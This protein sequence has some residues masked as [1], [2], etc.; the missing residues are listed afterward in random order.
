MSGLKRM[1]LHV[2]IKMI[3]FFN[4]LNILHDLYKMF[5]FKPSNHGQHVKRITISFLGEKN[6][7]KNTMG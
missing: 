3:I 4:I 2:I 7:C 6:V 5:A 1:V